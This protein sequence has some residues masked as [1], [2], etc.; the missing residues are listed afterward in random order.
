MSYINK[1]N[2]WSSFWLEDDVS[3]IDILTGEGFQI[4][5]ITLRW[6]RD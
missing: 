3:N 1:N 5:K 4:K 6:L 2:N